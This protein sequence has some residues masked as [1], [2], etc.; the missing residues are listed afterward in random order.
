MAIKFP[1]TDRT[2]SWLSSVLGERFGQS[3]N[4]SFSKRGLSLKLVGAADSIEF[5]TIFE[6]FTEAHSNQPYTMW[7]AEAEGWCSALGGPIPAPGVSKLSKKLI[8]TTDSGYI[9][10]YDIFGLMYWMLARVEEIDRT[11]L[12]S[13]GRFPATAS[14][15]HRFGYLNRPIVDEWMYILAQLISRQWPSI[16]L[17]KHT[18]SLALSHD[19]DRPSRYQFANSKNFFR[20]MLG[21]LAR[22]DMVKAF[23]APVVRISSKNTLHHLDPFN[24]FSWI[25]EQSERTGVQSTFY[26]ICRRDNLEV[27]GEYLLEYTA[28]RDLLRRIHSRGHMI[29]LHP[30]YHSYNDAQALAHELHILRNIC[31]Q[32]NIRQSEWGSRMH[33]LRWRQPA[34]IRLLAEAGISHDSTLTYADSPGFRCGTCFEYPAFDAQ[35]SE[36]LTIRIRPLIAMEASVISAKYL[37]LEP[38]DAHFTLTDLMSKCK[39]FRGQFSLLWHNSELM[40]GSL[41]REIYQLLINE[42]YYS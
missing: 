7:D 1:I 29:G 9:I 10:H 25:M 30:T 8:E 37:G 38:K 16:E 24:T 2:L 28:I 15:A 6:G 13:H 11:D 23:S 34:T 5:D 3:W 20:R 27:N 18:Y 32:E 22:G 21:D 4:L 12:D 17:K 39:T 36:S 35:A 33:Y 19:V 14:H 41:N 42:Q 40:E 26:F 31:E